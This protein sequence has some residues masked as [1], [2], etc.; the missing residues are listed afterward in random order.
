MNIFAYALIIILIASNIFHTTIPMNYQS[1]FDKNKGNKM[2]LVPDAAEQQ[3]KEKQRIKE[4]NERRAELYNQARKDVVDKSK[5]V[6]HDV[7]K[8][9]DTYLE[10]GKTEWEKGKDEL[11]NAFDQWTR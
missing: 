1:A 8:N 9:W 10:K 3:K 11:K 5:D 6:Y 2:N 4:E 7:E